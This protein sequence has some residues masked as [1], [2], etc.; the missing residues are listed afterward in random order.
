MKK[1]FIITILSFFSMLLYIPNTN[2][3]AF[4]TNVTINTAFDESIDLNNIE[5]IEVFIEDST[6]YSRSYVL[7]KD[8]NFTLNVKDVPIGPFIFQ[9]GVVNDDEIGYYRVSADININKETET[10]VVTVIV[11]LQNNQVYDRIP[12]TE[13]DVN[14]IIGSDEEEDNI[15]IDEDD[16]EDE[17][18]V[19]GSD[20]SEENED[21]DIL[22]EIKEEREKEKL[23][24]EK[25]ENRKKSNLIAR[26]MFSIIG[27]VIII[28]VLFVTI[29]I[30]RANK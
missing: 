13:D 29:K 8:N 25:E 26:I 28:G 18:I 20:K 19:I 24:K 6:E 7:E 9:Y 15:T 4:Y 22:D 17:D 2:A 30:S 23:E 3:V 12:L 11:T 14:N 16:E 27:I 5:W 21:E 1:I 10:V